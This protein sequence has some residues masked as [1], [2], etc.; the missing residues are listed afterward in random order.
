MLTEILAQ[1][2][3][4]NERFGITGILCSYEQNFIQCLEGSY[5]HVNRTYNRIISDTRHSAC[6][7]LSYDRITERLFDSWSMACAKDYALINQALVTTTKEQLFLSLHLIGQPSVDFM[8]YLAEHE[9]GLS[10][11]S[12]LPIPVTPQANWG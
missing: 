3:T 2:R 11:E 6:S 4:N 12:R 7:L 10:P 1:A 5:S 9:S 8:T